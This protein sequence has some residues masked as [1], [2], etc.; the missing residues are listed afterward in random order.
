[1]KQT[2]SPTRR[3][4]AAGMTLLELVVAVGILGIVGGLL[5]GTFS[6]TITSRE[7][8]VASARA[9]AAGRAAI[10][11]LER[12]LKGAFS[13]G[14]YPR[15]PGVFFSIGKADDVT[16]D[17]RR[18]LLELTT[19]SALGTAPPVSA[20]LVPDHAEHLPDEARVLYRLEDD[21]PDSETADS[22]P[23]DARAATQRTFALV[24]YDL[25]PALT[26]T[27]ALE[28]ASRAVIARG[29]DA[30]TLRFFD[31]FT[32]HESWDSRGGGGQRDSAPVVVEA[33]L[34]IRHAAAIE[35]VSLVSAV[36]LPLGGAGAP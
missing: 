17:E 21:D 13:T 3:S 25:R 29:I 18:P 31:G 20:A 19:V 24:R 1:M 26:G 4:P 2:E 32:W 8:A 22:S 5:Y 6:R 10:D 7:Y 34:E 11:W 15:G 27:D 9:F 28:H 30:V 23:T 12:D 33:R 14:S 16:L 36:R 35:P